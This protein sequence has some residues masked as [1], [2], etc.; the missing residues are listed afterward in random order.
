MSREFLLPDL[1][2]GIAEAQI[3]RVM[4]KD[5][6][7]VAEDQYLMEVETDKAAVEIP[8]PFAGIAKRVHVSEGQT[9]NVGEVIV[10]FDEGAGA[11]A[12]TTATAATTAVTAPSAPP[13]AAP[14]AAVPAPA[15][16][17][18]TTSPAAPAVRRLARERGVDIDDVVGT[19]PGGRVT[20]EDVERHA[21][22][23]TKASAPVTRPAPVPAAPLPGIADADKWGPIRREPINQIRKT[24]ANHMTRSAYTAVHVTHTDEVDITDLDGVRRDLNELTGNDPKMT[25]MAFVIRATCLAIKKHPIFNS[26]FD[27]EGGQIIYKDYVNMGIAVDTERGLIVPVIRNADQMSLRDIAAAL[28]SLADRI[29]A[30]QFGIEDLRGG[31]FTIT[32]VGALGG[33]YSTPIINYPEVAI[34]GLGRSRKVP[35]FKEG[36]LVEALTLPINLSFDHRATDGANAARFAGDLLSYLEHPARFLL[37]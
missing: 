23:G 34:L 29:R 25:L 10:T 28:R 33:M 37:D 21:G 35:A 15:G 19:G 24:I 26:S 27:E 7:V 16:S 11:A 6:D 8:S 13:K 22:G 2:E 32:N 20:R 4:I 18:K 17:R 1:G 5:G 9:V 36:E 12:T 31:T 30:N 3:I 14:P